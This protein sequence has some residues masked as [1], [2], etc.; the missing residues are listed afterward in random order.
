MGHYFLI[1][2]VDAFRLAGNG[3]EAGLA[4]NLTNLSKSALASEGACP[5][6]GEG[7]ACNYCLVENVQCGTQ[8]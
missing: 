7:V 2:E 4:D 6:S 1:S 5:A 3:Q 8:I